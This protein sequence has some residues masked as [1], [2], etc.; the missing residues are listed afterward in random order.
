MQV[1][2]PSGTSRNFGKGIG[3]I[4]FKKYSDGFVPAII[5]DADTNKVLMLGFMNEA[6]IGKNT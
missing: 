4:D 6:G 1:I 5:Q 2:Y 3:V